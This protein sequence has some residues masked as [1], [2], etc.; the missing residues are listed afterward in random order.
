MH[1]QAHGI[2][3]F[4]ILK[5]RA[6]FGQWQARERQHELFLE[7]QAFAGGHEHA[8]SRAGLEQFGDEVRSLDQV[9]A[10]VEHQ[11]HPPVA[12][13]ADRGGQRVFAVLRAEAE[14]LAERR[15]NLAG[16]CQRLER[17]ETNAVPGGGL[18]GEF[19]CHLQSQARLAD[20][21]RSKQGQQSRLVAAEQ[22][23]E[24]DQ[25]RVA[26][27]ERSPGARQDNGPK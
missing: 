3:Q 10:I 14:R 19:A 27:N 25:F 11:Q 18:L 22:R 16:V 12:D 20:T 8:Q 17:H 7:V 15:R 4:G 5:A 13:G 1:E 2:A 21:A 24:F 9:F 23:L 6:G 26:P